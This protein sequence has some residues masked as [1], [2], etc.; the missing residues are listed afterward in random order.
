LAERLVLDSEH[1]P[2]CTAHESEPLDWPP[3]AV[4]VSVEPVVNESL[5]VTVNPVWLAFPIVTVVFEDER[6]L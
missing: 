6:S 5:L 3:E 2:D 4:K 1:A